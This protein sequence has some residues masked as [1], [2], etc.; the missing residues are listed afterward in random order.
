MK[1]CS[2]SL[3]ICVWVAQVA[4]VIMLVVICSEEIRY[5]HFVFNNSEDDWLPGYWYIRQTINSASLLIITGA[6]IDFKGDYYYLEYGS[7]RVRWDVLNTWHITLEE[8]SKEGQQHLLWRIVWKLWH[9]TTQWV[10][11]K[12]MGMC[13]EGI[14]IYMWILRF[15]ST[16][17]HNSDVETLTQINRV[18]IKMWK[19]WYV[20]NE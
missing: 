8:P 3:S 20:S 14:I 19:L 12:G 4:Y 9:R 13:R 16:E 17:L 11:W 18:I 1:F 6:R 10:M 7:L 5:S 15:K 2:T